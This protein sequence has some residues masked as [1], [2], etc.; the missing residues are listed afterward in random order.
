MYAAVSVSVTSEHPRWRHQMP[1]SWWMTK[2]S[3][4]PR[5]HRARGMGKQHNARRNEIATFR[6]RQ[7]D[8]QPKRIKG[9]LFRLTRHSEGIRNVTEYCLAF[10]WPFSLPR[11]RAH[12]TRHCSAG[13]ASPSSGPSALPYPRVLPGATPSVR[14]ESA[15]GSARSPCWSAC[16]RAARVSQPPPVL[17]S[18]CRAPSMHRDVA[19]ARLLTW[20]ELTFRAI[21]D[22]ADRVSF[23]EAGPFS[24]SFP[25]ISFDSNT[26][27]DFLIH[28]IS[29]TYI[30]PLFVS[31]EKKLV[32]SR[33]ARFKGKF[34]LNFIL[35]V[36]GAKSLK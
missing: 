27:L 5:K 26:Y 11:H 8:K 12:V 1:I 19:H 20:P 6:T 31:V 2:A 10:S 30:F 23:C 3:P 21:R 28:S 32:L 36:T 14:R 18:I 33:R 16:K 35:R 24:L 17:T 9:R 7:T 34:D 13:C 4:R 15:S 29:V 22:L 25:L